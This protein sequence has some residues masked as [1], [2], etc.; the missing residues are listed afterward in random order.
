V[1][2]EGI[3]DRAETEST[4]P[5]SAMNGL[6]IASSGRDSPAQEPH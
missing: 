5:F 2:D 4:N 6:P 1:G 3:L